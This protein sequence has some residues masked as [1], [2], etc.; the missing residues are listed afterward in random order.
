M[1][2]LVRIL[3]EYCEDNDIQFEYGSE[4]HLNLIQGDI[5]NNRIYLLLF[6]VTR[7]TSANAGSIKVQGRRYVGRFM[8]LKGSDYANHYFKENNTDQ[9]TSKYT[10]NIEPLLTVNESILNG[11]MCADL[12][13]ERHECDDAI[14]V[15]DANK[16]GL[17]CRFVYVQRP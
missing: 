17:W 2:D 10:V 13:I 1:R 15:L 4:Q 5:D 16:D 6:P 11:L 8:L 12:E 14:N 9:A 7:R 3:E